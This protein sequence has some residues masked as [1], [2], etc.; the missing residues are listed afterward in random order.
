VDGKLDRALPH[1]MDVADG[2][3]RRDLEAD[4]HLA[5]SNAIGL[6]NSSYIRKPLARKQ[7]V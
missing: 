2:A 4:R 6:G 5:A 7:C 1:C 3:M